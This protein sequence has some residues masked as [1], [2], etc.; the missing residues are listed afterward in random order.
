MCLLIDKWGKL[1]RC[2]P[3]FEHQ[4][5]LVPKK[6]EKEVISCMW[7]TLTGTKISSY[8]S[9]KDMKTCQENMY[10]ETS[11]IK[12]SVLVPLFA[13]FSSTQGVIELIM[14]VMGLKREFR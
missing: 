2:I 11:L 1:D 13:C 3:V 14:D 5:S 4:V 8:I 7:P 9:K 10:I 12:G 6:L